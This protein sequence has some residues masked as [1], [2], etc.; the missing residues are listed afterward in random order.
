MTV[1]TTDSLATVDQEIAHRLIE[2]LLLDEIERLRDE[3]TALRQALAAAQPP[4]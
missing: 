4:F 3:N 2:T 1:V